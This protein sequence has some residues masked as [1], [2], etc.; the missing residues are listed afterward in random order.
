K[1]PVKNAQGLASLRAAIA[2]LKSERRRKFRV[3]VQLP[4]TLSW[5]DAPEVEGIMLDVS[6]DGMDVLS[7]QPLQGSQNV[8][9]E[10]SLPDLTQLRARA[11][12]VCANTNGQAGLQSADFPEE[13]RETLCACRSATSHELPAEPEAVSQC[14]V[15][16]RS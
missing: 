8:E 16:V 13:E 7:A 5:Q 3:P 1:K 10:F 12:V 14:K 15:T 2:L 11:Q 6:E 9:V 4:V